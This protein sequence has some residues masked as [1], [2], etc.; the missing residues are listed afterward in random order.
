MRGEIEPPDIKGM[1]DEEKE[2]YRFRELSIR[3]KEKRLYRSMMENRKERISEALR[4]KN[5]RKLIEKQAKLAKDQNSTGK[6]VTAK[7]SVQPVSGTRGTPKKKPK[8]AA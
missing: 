6:D 1:K 4:L 2:H 5:K 8:K 7:W 3:N